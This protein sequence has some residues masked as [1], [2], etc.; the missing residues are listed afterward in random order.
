MNLLYYLL[1]ANVYLIIFYGFYRILLH[2]ETFYSLNRY[3]LLLSTFLA[4]VIPFFQ[5][6]FLIKEM[7]IIEEPVYQQIVVEK[8]LLSTENILLFIYASI[9]LIFISRIVWGFR[10]I[11]K[12]LKKPNKVV[13][14]GVT[15]VELANTKTAFSFFNMLFIDPALPNKN[16]I[17]THEMAH[18]RQKHSFDII[19]FELVRSFSWFNPIAHLLRKDIKL[20]HEYLADEDATKEGIQKYDYALFLIQNSYG[21]QTLQLTNQIFNSSILKRRITMLNQKKS[22][23]WARLRVLLILP[24]VSGMLCAS[25]MAFTK[26]YGVVDLYP[27]GNASSFLQDTT[28]RVKAKEIRIAEPVQKA[29]K[30]AV[31]EIVISEPIQPANKAKG[32]KLPPPPPPPVAPPVSR[33]VK[34]VKLAPP[35]PPPVA[36]PVSKKVKGVK[37]APPPPP[38]VAPPVSKKTKGVKLP[39]PPPPAEPGDAKNTDLTERVVNGYPGKS[40]RLKAQPLKSNGQLTPVIVKGYKITEKTKVAPEPTNKHGD[41]AAK[42][43]DAK[44]ASAKISLQVKDAITKEIRDARKKVAMAN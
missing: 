22:A 5:L 21:E 37:L 42:S 1:E 10:H 23:K 44:S 15:I 41:K 18:I 9:A 24:V 33:K 28:K 12:L 40:G 32:T 26:D 34:G 29:K 43:S 13:E 11:F 35:P 39:P 3:Y 20:I 19:F 4:F 36:P 25:T 7:V 6:G 31:K 27:K 2:N 16:T 8:P 38:P 17:L 14:N 30:S